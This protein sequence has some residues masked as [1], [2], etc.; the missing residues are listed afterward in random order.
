VAGTAPDLVEPI[1]LDTLLP[2]QGARYREIGDELNGDLAG[3]GAR[4]VQLLRP[5]LEALGAWRPGEVAA[6]RYSDRYLHAPLPVRLA[7]DAAAALRDALAPGAHL[8]LEIATDELRANDRQPFA[9]THNWQWAED[10]D[11]VLMTLANRRKLRLTLETG[12]AAHGRSLLLRFTDGQ[13]ARVVLDQ[14][15]GVWE[16]PRFARFDFGLNANVQA[17][18][19]GLLNAML[20]ARGRSYLVVAR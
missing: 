16:T 15:F 2:R 6:L 1:P 4:F 9:P 20:N 17:D 7:L 18:K 11:D 8:D 10:R 13:S 12:R 14:G 5:E 19:L 3:F